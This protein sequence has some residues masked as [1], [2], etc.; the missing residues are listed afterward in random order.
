MLAVVAVALTAVDLSRPP[1]WQVSG[2]L[3][4]AAIA[5][6]QAT[7]SRPLAGLGARCRFSPTCSRYADTCVRRFGAGR[8]GW[9]ALKRL[10]RCGPWTPAG[11]VDPPPT[12][13]APDPSPQ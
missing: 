10:L 3:L 12:T 13:L 1:S 7:L 2:R 6:Y 11:T 4:C 8:G 9:M 5:G